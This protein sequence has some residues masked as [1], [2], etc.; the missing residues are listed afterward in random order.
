MTRVWK[1]VFVLVALLGFSTTAYAQT[2]RNVVQLAH[3]NNYSGYSALTG[4]VHSDGREY[5]ALGTYTGTSILNITNPSAP[6]EV[7]FINGPASA[8]R[9]MKQYRDHIYI[10]SEGQGQGAGLQIVRMTDPQHPVLVSTYTSTFLTAH[11]V[12]IDTTR[13][14][15]YANGTADGMHQLS[16]ANP[17]NPVD[18]GVYTDHYVH[19]LHVRGTRGYASCISDGLEVILDLRTPGTFPQLAAFQTPDKFTHNSW[20]TPDSHYIYC[21]DETSTPGTMSAWDI[22]NLSNIFMVANYKG[23]PNDIVHNV[24]LKGDTLFVAYY[25]AGVRLFDITDPTTPVEFGYYDTS[26]LPGPAFDGVWDVDPFLPSGNF[27]ASDIE[28]G[29]WVFRTQAVYGTVR[30]TV[31]DAS[32]SVPIAGAKVEL[33]GTTSSMLTYPTGKYGFSPV[34]GTY[35]VHASAFGYLGGYAT[36]GVLDGVHSVTNLALTPLPTSA[37]AG[38][39]RK[40]SDMTALQGA[41]LAVSSTPLAT[42]SASN[43]TYNFPNVPVGS[44]TITAEMP[45]F[46]PASATVSVPGGGTVMQ[47][48]SL[49]AAPF[50]DDAEADRGWSL[51]SAGDNATTGRWIRADPIGTGGGTVQPEDDHTPG[52]GV[53][54]YVTGNGSVGGGIG[55]A[56]V[57]NGKTTLTT[58]T[59]NLSGVTDPVIVFWQ[60]YSNSAGGAP[61]SDTFI[62]D[63]SNN[64]GS[65]WKRVESLIAT[66]NFWERIQ[67][68]VSDFVTPSSNMKVRFIAQDLGVGSV[69][70]AAID[71][72]EYYSLASVTG[73]GNGLGRRGA[74]PLALDV[75]GPN[76][77]RGTVSMR[78]TLGA[79]APVSAQVFDARGRLVRTLAVGTWTAGSHELLWDGQDARG[80]HVGAG[81]YLIRVSTP[82]ENKSAEIIRL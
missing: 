63:I 48:F 69:V 8:W 44:H 13:A 28:N 25:T 56:D 47:D 81:V 32:T 52:S 79:A 38:T 74:E 75:V 40:A 19:D 23:L 70:E 58:P 68:H 65:T 60:W 80:R 1:G 33:V 43:G 29:L 72:L 30:G 71:D 76:P 78:L 5:A 18:L 57:D 27:I 17:E 36:A 22:S 54:C 26:T 41:A 20:T 61:M 31:T 49:T 2:N 16:L 34:S 7:A 50:Y 82:T 12:T 73:V 59:L 53:A 4:Y 9:E 10:V 51:V 66:H 35:E 37:V 21:T 14:L 64:G 6:V 39:V 46:I 24:R 3:V 67:V 45:G 11:T 77:A 62:V 42:S 55:E 15:L